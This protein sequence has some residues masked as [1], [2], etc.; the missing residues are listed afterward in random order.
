V[1][2]MEIIKQGPCA[3]ETLLQEQYR[4]MMATTDLANDG[5]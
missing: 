5:S 3:L 2:W 1:A 4:P